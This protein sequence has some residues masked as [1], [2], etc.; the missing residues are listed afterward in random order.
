VNEPLFWA[1]LLGL[2]LFAVSVRALRGRPFLPGRAV[3]LGPVA[4]TLAVLGAIALV[5]HCSAM[6]FAPWVSAVAPL[7]PLVMHVNAMGVASQVAYWVPAAAL[8]VAW[9]RVWWPALVL[10]VALFAGV[11]VTMYWPYPL[12]VH[13]SWLAAVI[14]AGVGVSTALTGRRAAPRTG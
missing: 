6:F 3:S 9:R 1:G 11:G 13:L 7:R 10:M 4:R 8:L 14:I 12:I 5:F 2:A